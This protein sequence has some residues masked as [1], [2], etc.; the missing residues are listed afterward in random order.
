MA[1]WPYEDKMNRMMGALGS[2]VGLFIAISAELALAQVDEAVSDLTAQEMTWP[3]GAAAMAGMLPPA[4]ILTEVRQEGFYPVGRP[5][6][7]GRVYVLFAIDQDDMDVRLTVDGASGQVLWV[8]AAVARFGGPGYYGRRSVWREH[9]PMPPADIPAAG[10]RNSFGLAGTHH[11]SLKRFPPLPRTRPA[12]LAEDSVLPAQG[13]PP[14]TPPV[15]MV[16][17]APLEP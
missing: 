15:T 10:S 5:V 13:S 7:R 6:Q 4:E 11:T 9:P 14:A 17:V 1:K 2:A 3:A 16:P 12:D 8:T